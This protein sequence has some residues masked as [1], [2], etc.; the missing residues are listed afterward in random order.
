[1]KCNGTI[2]APPQGVDRWKSISGAEELQ[3]ARRRRGSEGSGPADGFVCKAAAE[4]AVGE[5]ACVGG[6]AAEGESKGFAPARNC[7]PVDT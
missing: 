1:M 2:R 6:V 4:I 3:N 7:F 5:V